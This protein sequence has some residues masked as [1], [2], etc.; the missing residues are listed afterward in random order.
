MNKASD[1]S[2]DASQTLEK[3]PGHSSRGRLERV[4]RRGEFAVTA[5]LN[6][7]DSANPWEVYDRGAVFDGW[8]DAINATDGSGANCHMSSVGICAL[9]T[10]VG[11]APILQISCRDRNRIAIQGDVLGA[12][13]MGVNNILCLT[14]DGVQAGD[15]P[16]A[17]PV[18]DLD[19]ISLLETIRTL[20]DERQFLSG[21]K[22]SEP[23][24]VFLGAAINPFAPPHEFRPLR[25]KKKIEAGAQF[26]QSQ[27]C[28]DVPILKDYMQRV[29]DMRLHEECFILIG[30]G[31]L[32]SAQ[33]ARWIRSN[34]P[35]VHIPK[36]I[37]KS[38]DGANDQ[39]QEGKQICIEIIQ[40]IQDIKG[41]SG[42]HVMAYRQEEL[43]A[44]II[45]KS[46]IIAHRKP[47]RR[48]A[49]IGNASIT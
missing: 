48:A 14:G 37:I 34:V 4:L 39:Q 13:A 29:T 24:Q 1:H 12:A 17:K 36:H 43:V 20:R 15:Q 46:G 47:W 38:L 28:Y 16:G 45:Q 35:G 32:K 22:I 6:P 18:F 23:P 3:L 9:L 26:V 8:V 21:R 11:Y 5:E 7:P 31:P 25:L 44:D 10:R 19:C 2:V 27:Y 41:V 33:A 49:D 30:V 40:E 42:V